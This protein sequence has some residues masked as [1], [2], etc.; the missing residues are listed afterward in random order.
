M[1]GQMQHKFTLRAVT[2]LAT[3][4]ICRNAASLESNYGRSWLC[5]VAKFPLDNYSFVGTCILPWHHK[6]MRSIFLYLYIMV[7]MMWKH[8][9]DWTMYYDKLRKCQNDVILHCMWMTWILNE[10]VMRN[11]LASTVALQNYG[12]PITC[13]Y[14]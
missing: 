3:W 8:N 12:N 2:I 7:M 10:W 5:C 13:I 11:L 1:E 6:H 4:F 14:D 9:V